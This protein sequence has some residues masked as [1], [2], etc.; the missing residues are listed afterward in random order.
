M[1][2]YICL[3]KLTANNSSR[4]H[5]INRS[6]GGHITSREL[7]CR[8]CNSHLGLTIDAEL[9][10][11]LGPYGFLLNIPLQDSDHQGF[12]TMITMTG[13][14]I[15]V[16][17]GMVPYDTLRILDH[18]PQPIELPV[19]PGHL[20][21]MMSKKKKELERSYAIESR[22]YEV[23]PSREKYF[24]YDERMASPD[25]V[26]FGGQDCYR[27]IAKMLLNF[28]LT[29]H[30]P[31]AF[32]QSVLQFVKG[33]SSLPLLHYHPCHR[34]AHSIA[35]EEVTHILHLSGEPDS[36]LLYGY[37]ELFNMVKLIVPFSEQYVGPPIHKTYIWE[38]LK[39]VEI[40]KELDLPIVKHHLEL[41]SLD[42]PLMMQR[43][44]YSRERLMKLIERRQLI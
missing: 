33:D 36:G 6:I 11:Q 8:Q 14:K 39:G 22:E 43:M 1:E 7:L 25:D 34:P 17:P 13:R 42:Q 24:I 12:V 41:L 19:A 30:H 38:V 37:V 10:R 15:R 9:D 2:C 4:E 3:E 44:V 27:S 21:K 28:Y 5:I 31:L 35:A 32:C 40:S 18:T 26:F 20:G 23:P 29:Q 16:A